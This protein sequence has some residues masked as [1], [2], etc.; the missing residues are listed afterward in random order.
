MN[1]SQEDL[2][3]L[4]P[5]SPR[6]EFLFQI[7]LTVGLFLS[8]ALVPLVGFFPGAL[9]P[10]PTAIAV[11]RWGFPGAWLVPGCS[12]VIGALLL[13]LFNLPESIPYLL[14]LLGMGALLG[15]GLRSEWP[16]EKIVG[17]SS[18]FVLGMA[19]LFLILVFSEAKD[20]MV[21][22][23]E[24]DLQTAISSALK[25]FGGSSLEIQELQSKLVETVPMMVRT[26][27]G[28][29]ISSILGISWLN[30]LVARRYCRTDSEPCQAEKLSLWKSPEFIVWFVV[31]GGLM[32]V[33]PVGGLKIPGINL[34]IVMGAIYFLQG[35]AIMAFYFERWKLPFVVKGFVYAVL[36]LQQFAS[37]ATAALGLFDTWFDFRKLAKKQA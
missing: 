30:L 21:A 18:L 13:Y 5:G 2:P 9:T 20:G 31:A 36:F 22:L 24:Q 32:V 35:L 19:G 4:G 34:L 15:Y 3:V 37:M 12:A 28:V 26:M 17:F 14:A 8:I 11:I 10:A 27:P 29:I 6:K 7:V 1:S 16:A 25:E 33:L 23:I